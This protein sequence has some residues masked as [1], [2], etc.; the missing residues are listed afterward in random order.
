[1]SGSGKGVGV[2]NVVFM[3]MG[4]PLNN[5][6]AVLAALGPMTDPQCFALAPARC[7]VSTV[8]VIPN[9]RRLVHDAPG[10]SLALSLH[11]PNQRL[12]EQ[13]VPTATAYKLPALMAALDYYLASGPKV[14]TMVEY[15]VLGGVNDSEEC[16]REL[17]ELLRGR[18]I[19]LNL[20]PYNPTD[21]PMAGGVGACHIR[22]GG[23]VMRVARRV[24]CVA[25]RVSRAACCVLRAACCALRAAPRALRLAS[26]ALRI[27]G[28]KFRARG[29]GFR[30]RGSG[31]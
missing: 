11:A 25:R 17:G 19:I 12:R 2:R 26:C 7:T 6:D 13:I 22:M 3:G 10:V 18:D 15:C 14:R 9:M 20:I 23:C 8:G 30:V 28:P 1:V 29:S 24:L 5:Y 27:Q 16:A 21:V 4:E 31:L